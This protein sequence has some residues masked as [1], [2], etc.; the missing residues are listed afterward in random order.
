MII[1]VP[2]IASLT[3]IRKLSDPVNP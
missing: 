3:R 2:S 1:P